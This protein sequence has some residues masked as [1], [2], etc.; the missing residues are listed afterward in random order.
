MKHGGAK[1]TRAMLA[2]GINPWNFTVGSLE[3]R[4]AARARLARMESS[5]PT[6]RLVVSVIGKPTDLSN[7]KFSR[8]LWP[9]GTVFEMAELDGA[10]N[11]VSDE[12]LDAIFCKLPVDGAN[13]YADGSRYHFLTPCVKNFSASSIAL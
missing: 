2:D 1:Q 10:D 9:D 3:S 13:Y 6:A 8:Q 4:A 5:R 7:C 11:G 12:Q